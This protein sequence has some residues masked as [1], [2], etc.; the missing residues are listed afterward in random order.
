MNIHR[1]ERRAANS[2]RQAE[3]VRHARV[4]R[5]AQ[6]PRPGELVPDFVTRRKVNEAWRSGDGLE[7]WSRLVHTAL[8]ADVNVAT[9]ISVLR[10][11]GEAV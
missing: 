5:R 3:R 9:A 10:S 4:C 11:T 1:R 8:R 2:K 7:G 6:A